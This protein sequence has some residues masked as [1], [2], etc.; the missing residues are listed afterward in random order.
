MMTPTSRVVFDRDELEQGAESAGFSEGQNATR[1]L[2]GSSREST[3]L[4]RLSPSLE[5]VPG[6]SLEGEEK[7]PMRRALS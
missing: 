3:F 5:V 4:Y 1:G 6:F 2:L 7:R